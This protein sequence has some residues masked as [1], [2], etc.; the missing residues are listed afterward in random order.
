[1]A[2]LTRKEIAHRLH[3]GVTCLQGLINKGLFPKPMKIGRLSRWK[4]DDVTEVYLKHQSLAI[5]FCV[6]SFFGL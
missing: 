1:M 4:K 5:G 3:I 2:L 6:N